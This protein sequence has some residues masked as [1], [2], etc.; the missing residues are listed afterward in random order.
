MPSSQNKKQTNKKTKQTKKK[1]KKNGFSMFCDPYVN[2]R[3]LNPAV[4]RK[5]EELIINSFPALIPQSFDT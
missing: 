4:S 3:S 5:R 1:N 2:L